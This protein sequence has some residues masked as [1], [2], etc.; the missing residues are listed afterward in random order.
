MIKRITIVLLCCIALLFS[1]YAGYRGYKVWKQKR[2]M[3]LAQEFAEQ[4]D[5]RNAM[6]AVQQALRLNPL[7]LDATRLAARMSDEL[8]SP[9]AFLWRSR[10]VELDPNSVE[11]RLLLVQTAMRFGDVRAATNA[12]DGMPAAGKLT[13]EYHNTAGT[14]AATGNR[15]AQA[16]EHLLEALRLQPT[17]AI[18]D[19]NLAILR[20]GNTNEP[21]RAQARLDL[22][23]LSLDRR[24]ET[25]AAQALRE[26]VNDA[27]R[28]GA[29]SNALTL[30]QE[31]V[32]H[33]QAGFRERLLRLEVLHR[34]ESPDLGPAL[35]AAQNEAASG[36][37]ITGRIYQLAD[38]QMR[39]TT[40][41]ETLTWL[42]TLP[43]ET[44]TNQPV[45]LM[46]ADCLAALSDWSTLHSQLQ[47]QD[48][49][50][51]DF[52]RHA[53]LSRSLRNQ[54]L[55]GG[56]R[57]EWELALKAANNQRAALSMLLRLAA[58]WEWQSEGEEVLWAIYNAFPGDQGAFDA[59]S[60]V[61]YMGGRTRPLMMIFGQEVKR[62]PNNLEAKNNLALAALLLEAWELKPHELASEVHAKAPTNAAFASTHAFSLHL[63]GKHTEALQVIQ[64]IPPAELEKPS[65][66]GYY[67]IIL[68][69]NGNHAAAKA[70]LS[71]AQG[72]VMLPEEKLMFERALQEL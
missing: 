53:Y 37:N 45:A 60:R 69:G 40:P 33:A 23:R 13:F 5:Y 54:N 4:A 50:E 46:V 66:A 29:L 58:L 65:M 34:S 7:N 17:N 72:T 42:E 10:V 30:S 67:G 20:L 22:R 49:A 57:G 39:R 1:G 25:V 61:L 52:V 56:A 59:L 26:L 68:K 15:L 9:S 47:N 2:H 44:R 36:T 63:Q 62:S 14:L 55:A 28:T 18:P 51:L 12:L 48:W 27:L 8:G 38:W 11:D 43:A 71:R 3:S 6:L 41:R 24:H 32:T 70:S 64:S 31:L 19:L 16:E 21:V 35:E